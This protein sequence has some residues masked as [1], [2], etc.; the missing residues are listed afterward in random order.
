MGILMA[1]LAAPRALHALGEGAV[2]PI[3]AEVG[4]PGHTQQTS[5]VVS[6]SVSDGLEKARGA[7]LLSRWCHQLPMPCESTSSGGQKCMSIEK[8]G[9]IVRQDEI[10]LCP[11]PAESSLSVGTSHLRLDSA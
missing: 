11:I 6:E 4:S 9:A 2:V 3:K 8:A 1:L 5:S 7:H 10:D